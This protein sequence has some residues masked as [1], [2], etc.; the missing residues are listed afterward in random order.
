MI[1]I[2]FLEVVVISILFQSFNSGGHYVQSEFIRA[3]LS[4]I[5]GLFKD[6]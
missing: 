5:Q 2:I 6:F 1:S 4:Q 3:S